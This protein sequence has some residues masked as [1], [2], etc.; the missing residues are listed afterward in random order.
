MSTRIRRPP[1]AAARRPVIPHADRV[2]FEELAEDFLND[3]RV[4]RKRSLD[5][6]E[7]SVKRLKRCFALTSG[8]GG[9]GKTTAVANLAVALAAQGKK[10]VCLDGD[11][12]LRNLDV[13]MGL[14]NR[15]QPVCRLDE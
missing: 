12:G 5:R 3:Y 10:V 6:A 4:N 2:R 14:E 15:M 9:V 13:I 7:R 8:K 11:I 1:G